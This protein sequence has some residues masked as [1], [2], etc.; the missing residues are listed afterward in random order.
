MAWTLHALLRDNTHRV[1]RR[2]ASPLQNIQHTGSA[3]LQLLPKLRSAVPLPT[4]NRKQSC[5]GAFNGAPIVN[6]E[7]CVYTLRWKRVFPM[8][9]VRKWRSYCASI[10]HRSVLFFWSSKSNND[11]CNER[12]NR[13]AN[14]IKI[15]FVVSARVPN[16][17]KL[18]QDEKYHFSH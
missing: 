10:K 13:E 2:V 14:K 17:K 11:Y 6:L 9:T 15:I 12:R 8:K 1:L 18:A 4:L 5:F 16:F 3:G 7:R